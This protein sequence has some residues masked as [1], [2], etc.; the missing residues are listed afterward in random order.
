MKTTELGEAWAY[1]HTPCGR[2]GPGEQ[3]GSEGSR[4]PPEMQGLPAAN[5][6]LGRS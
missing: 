5:S 1:R 3:R 2:T 4:L 6:F